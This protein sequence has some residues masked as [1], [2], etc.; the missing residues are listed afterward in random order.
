MGAAAAAT[1]G[2]IVDSV[3]NIDARCWAAASSRAWCLRSLINFFNSSF[4]FSDCLSRI[5]NSS[6][7]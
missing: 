3:F 2:I 5:A 4:S 6:E 1:I 7:I